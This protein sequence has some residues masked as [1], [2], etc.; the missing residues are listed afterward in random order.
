[1][2]DDKEPTKEAKEKAE[3]IKRQIEKIKGNRLKYRRERR[4]RAAELEMK[5]QNEDIG[6]DSKRQLQI[7]YFLDESHSLR[8]QRSDGLKTKAS[9]FQVI[10][11]IGKGAFGEVRIV[12]HKKNL[13]ILAMKTMLKSMMEAK[14]QLGHIVAER[15]IMTDAESPW[16]VTLFYAFQDAKYLYLVMEFCGGGDLMG[17]LIKK[18]ILSESHT[19]FYM[20]ELAAAINYVHELGYVHRDLKP[21]NVLIGND[22]HI[23]LSDFGLAKSFQSSNDKQLDNWQQYVATLKASDVKKMKED[24]KDDEPTD[25]RGK[26]GKREKVDRKKLYSTVGTPD[27]IAIEVLYQKGYDKKVDW[28]SM[29]VIMFECLVGYPPFYAEDPLQTC[30][31]IVHYRKYFKIPHDAKLS[32][33]GVDLIHNLVCSHRRRYSF[34]QI[35]NHPFFKQVPFE[36]LMKMKPPFIPQLTS[37]TDSSHFDAIEAEQDMDKG[38]DFKPSKATDKT[39]FWGYTFKRPLDMSSPA[40]EKLMNDVGVNNGQK[41]N[42]K[43]KPKYK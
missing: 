40:M 13:K 12:R 29:G 18:D 25:R 19:R 33:E 41:G 42:S 27:Y 24:G 28:W 35:K 8:A 39:H 17:L 10:K 21:D 3:H 32:R 30:R 22:G 1:M 38:S 11:I 7:Q 6:Q 34:E 26:G 36:N 9:D 5:L 4:K 16:L 15:D 20:S 31:K 2:A 14:N 37:D 23:R 43:F